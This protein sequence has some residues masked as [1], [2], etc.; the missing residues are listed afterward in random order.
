MAVDSAGNVYVADTDN[1]TIR[2]VTPGGV[3]TTLAG[4]AGSSG[5][6]DGTGSAARF[7]Q[8][9]GVAVDSAGNVYVADSGN[10]TIRKVTPGGVVTTLAGL[11]GSS[12]SADGTGSAARFNVP[13]GVAVDSAG[14]VYVADGGNWTI[15]KV[16]PGGVVTTLAGLA[17]SWGS[18]DGAGSAAR[19][20]CPQGVAV[21]SAGN[22]YVA[23]SGNKTI[24][25]VTL[26][27]VVSTLAGLSGSSGSAE[28]TGSA[29]RF[30]WPQ[31]VAVD[32]AGGVY[33]ADSNNNTIRFGT[34]NT[35]PDAPT[36]DV[37]VGPAGDTRQLDTS[38]QTAVAWQWRLIRV[39]SGSSASLS[40]ANVRDP[41]FTPDVA[42]L[43]VFRLE[44][45]NAAGAICIRTLAFTAVWPAPSNAPPQITEQPAGVR[46]PV[47]TNFT[48]SVSASGNPPL[49]Y[50]WYHA[51]QP[52]PGAVSSVF[53]V[54]NAALSDSGDYQV[55]VS[56]SFGGTISQVAQVVVGY[57]LTLTTNGVG[58]IQATPPLEVYEPGQMVQLTATPGAGYSFA[59]W[60]GDISATN[61][62]LTLTMDASKHVEAVFSSQP[63][64]TV[65]SW[66][67]Q[68][69]PMVA[70]G[71]RYKAVS[72]GYLHSLALTQ[73]GTVV[74]WGDNRYGEAAVPSGLSGVVAIAVGG[75]HSLALKQDGTV[76]AWGA[77]N[78]GQ[79]T[80]PSGLSGVIAVSAGNWHSLALKQDGTV[81]AWGSNMDDRGNYCGQLTVP[82]GLNGV[83]GI[84][85][86]GWH[87]LAL[88]QD[89]TVVAW[90]NNLEGQ[91][92]VPPDLSA[93]GV[94]AI[95]AG[96]YHNLALKQ[97]GTV[98]AW[99][100]GEPGQSAEWDYGQSTVPDGLNR[101]VAI[102]A[103]LLHSLALKQDG[104]VAMWGYNG[105]G[106]ATV[107]PG[108]SGGGV[109]A[110]A[111]GWFH[112]LALKQDG[113][114]VGW[115]W[116]GYAQATAPPGLPGPDAIAIAAGGYHSLA[117]THYGVVCAWGDNS[118]G[119][120]T[121]PPDV[122][123][124]G[125]LAIAAGG[126]HSLAL[127]QDGT[128]V[129]WGDNYDSNGRLCGQATVPGGLSG[130]IAIAA[131]AYHSLAL[132]QDGTVAAWG[133]NDSGQGTV[134]PE[135]SGG[136]VVAIAAGDFHS[137]ALKQ[138]GTVVAWGA[139][140]PGQS[141][142]PNY[143][144]ATVP[145]GLTG[146]I[147]IAAGGYHS[148]ALEAG[149]DGRRVGRRQASTIRGSEL[150]PSDRAS[151][152]VGKRGDRH[153]GRRV[154]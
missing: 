119:Q 41:S 144:Q 18:A 129:G 68:T 115:G 61:N 99:G 20:Y 114:I 146:A 16:T 91:T 145:G 123:G 11:A 118:Y 113:T 57:L 39:P 5:S 65:V 95:A 86:G 140:G 77:D 14:N 90:G 44:A 108:V 67:Q 73:D 29:A 134:P 105:F 64:G 109:S 107:P 45:T 150:W 10:H 121:V 60:Q 63:A 132:K 94:M 13:C 1:D 112:S 31:G 72:A 70:S 96:G 79:A 149:R 153:C 80:V 3:V 50:Q 97:D 23:D 120:I 47:G 98:V 93:G 135:L 21:D 133:A 49:T 84:A 66:G 74:A 101:V 76:V 152:L 32:S 4:L 83:T 75:Y 106:E 8:P 48:L 71:T 36:I 30:Y 38:P 143:G 141:G 116:D 110:V 102:A 22:V 148:L 137:L 122:P 17:G 127:E 24:R 54:T 89:G 154:S 92:A 139:G 55:T 104:T 26:G 103:G 51:G 100:A 34:T 125:V 6:A 131:G 15:R 25:K 142:D 85:A 87:N 151:R 147:A 126:R 7:G 128:V 12:G 2:K 58:S 59:G 46:V 42:D 81:V 56:N 138:D 82:G 53:S 33:V 52:V 9:C 111:A 78:N 130:V 19:F 124:S 43:Y 35:C 28:G 88:K 117:L 40:A 37:A 27:R 136:G 69:M 62:P